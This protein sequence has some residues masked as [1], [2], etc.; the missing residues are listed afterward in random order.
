MEITK[1]YIESTPKTPN[2]DFNP[3][4]GELILAG[5]SIPEN[6]ALVYERVLKW[7][8]EYIKLP[9]P[10][11]NFRINLEYFNTATAIWLSKIVAALCSIE[12]EECTLLIHLY[13]NIED[14]EYM[15]E[16]DIKD[17]LHPIIHMIGN[18]TISVAIKLYGTDDN[19]EILKQSMVL[20]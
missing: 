12:K 17:E 5:K 8:S 3:F 2:I 13:I 10:T 1:L 16:E 4:T 20:I 19:G 7:V 15:D 11:T 6:A 9:R 14:Y 18:P